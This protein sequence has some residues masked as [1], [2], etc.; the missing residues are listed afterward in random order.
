MKAIQI[1]GERQ[2]DI[3]NVE[4]QAL[5]ANEVMLRL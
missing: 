2:M 3:V 1:S 5:Q 4:E